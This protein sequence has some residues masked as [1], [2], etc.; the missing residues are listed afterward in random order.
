MAAV[1][2]HLQRHAPWGAHVKVT[3]GATGSGT[4][5]P[6]EGPAADAA[7]AAFVEAW[8]V[9]PVFMGQGGSIPMV[10][11]FQHAFPDATVL[12]TAVCDPDSRPH[13]IDES[14]D[15]GDFHKACLAEALLLQKLGDLA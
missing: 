2:E 3:D 15:L 11:D 6:F 12:V 13:G 5:I 9:E 10:A 1:S 8:G 7:R 4:T 14:L